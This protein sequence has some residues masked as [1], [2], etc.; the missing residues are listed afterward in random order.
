VRERAASVRFRTLF[1]IIYF[2]KPLLIK[3][4]NIGISVETSFTGSRGVRI[5]EANEE[6]L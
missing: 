4:F 5:S 6:V 2:P 3:R 1:E